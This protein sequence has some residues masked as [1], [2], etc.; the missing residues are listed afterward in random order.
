MKTIDIGKSGLTAPAILAG[1]MRIGNMTV[2]QADVFV[3]TALEN[4]ISMFDHADIYGAGSCEE[5]FGRVL[6][7]APSLRDRMLIQTK[8]GIRQGYYDFSK[9]HILASVEGSLR[10]LHTD[11]LDLLLLHRPDTL[12]EPEEVAEAF[13]L[14]QSSGKV[15]RF[16]VS[17]Q[18]PAQMELLQRFLSQKLVANQLQ[19]SVTNTGMINSG[20]NVNTLGAGAVDRDGSVL[21]YC[22]LKEI[23]IQAWSPFQY[24]FFEGVFLGSEKY[25]Q[26]NQVIG[27]LAEQYG[28]TD[29]AIAAAWI[30]RHPA[31]MQV[32]LGTTNPQ[33][34]CAIAKAADIRLTRQE[35]YEIYRAAGNT[36]P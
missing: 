11:H 1:C 36:L 13:G 22:R 5:L 28:V 2:G 27:R 29:S 14:L 8:C 15:R 23:T 17:N 7:E 33:R 35:W 10:R 9:E 25:P 18:N 30:L 20:I 19:L 12:M 26:V 21:E 16:G 32:V 4:G 34:L 24:G 6:A 31:N 3:Q